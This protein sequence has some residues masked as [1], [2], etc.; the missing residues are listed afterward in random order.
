MAII[1]N[2]LFMFRA[3]YAGPG[4]DDR[5]RD[6]SKQLCHSSCLQPVADNSCRLNQTSS[7]SSVWV[8]KVKVLVGS[9]VIGVRSSALRS[10]NT[11]TTTKKAS[12]LQHRLHWASDKRASHAARYPSDTSIRLPQSVS[13]FV[14]K[15]I[16]ISAHNET[17]QSVFCRWHPTRRGAFMDRQK[18][19]VVLEKE[20][21]PDTIARVGGGRL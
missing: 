11:H 2:T 16:A 20:A 8:S 12:C 6:P 15:A 21:W 10:P 4:N 18:A 14:G 1:T 17:G 19:A 9:R 3:A 7:L 5:P 13:T